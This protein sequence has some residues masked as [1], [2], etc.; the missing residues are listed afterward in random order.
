MI[1]RFLTGFSGTDM[2][3]AA[4]AFMG[5]LFF[6]LRL[7]WMFVG[8]I[9]DGGHA[10]EAGAGHTTDADGSEAAFTLI[11]VNTITAFF[12]MSGWIGL[13]CSR[14]FALGVFPS[15]S[16]GFAA[17]AL[18]MALTAYFFAA[19]LKLASPGERFE[20]QQAIGLTANVYQTI[21]AGGKGK[22]Q[23]V[24]RGV[25]RELEAI[26]ENQEEIASFQNVKVV[27]AID[28]QTVAVSKTA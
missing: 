5:T 9:D 12:M 25:G 13:A 10:H 26:S 20:I 11:S 23:V 2:V 4:F 1:E 7:A 8:G 28:H 22:I 24:I 15:V 21:P 14:Q 17:G 27:R 3:F 18:S 19:A 16:L 6:F